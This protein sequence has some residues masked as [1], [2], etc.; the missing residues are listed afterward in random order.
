MNVS[1][2]INEVRIYMHNSVKVMRVETALQE[3]YPEDT[4]E[5]KNDA[6]GIYVV[7]DKIQIWIY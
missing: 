6:R 2:L 4:P 3:L 1:E 7:L 5:I